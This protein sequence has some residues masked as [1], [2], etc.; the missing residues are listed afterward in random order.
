MIIE[1]RPNKF[2][3]EQALAPVLNDVGKISPKKIKKSVT[4]ITIDIIPKSAFG[5]IV[6]PAARFKPKRCNGVIEL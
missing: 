2:H 5:F 1:F 3:Q 4:K 6:T